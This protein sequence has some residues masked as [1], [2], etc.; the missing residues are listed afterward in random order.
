MMFYPLT[1]VF[2]FTWLSNL[3]TWCSDLFT[4]CKYCPQ[5]LEEIVLVGGFDT[6]LFL[7]V[8]WQR[9]SPLP[10]DENQPHTRIASG[11]FSFGRTQ[12][13]WQCSPFQLWINDFQK[14][15]TNG[16]RIHQKY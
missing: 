2:L 13:S 10:L 16:Q 12:G 15:Q 7:A 9:V 8:L 11:G 14:S 3:S 6:R 1:N 4:W 5:V